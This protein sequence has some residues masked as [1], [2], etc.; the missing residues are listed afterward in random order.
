MPHGP[1]VDLSIVVPMY[2]E[3]EVID[4]FFAR[5]HEVL[6]PLDLSWEIVAVNDGSSDQTLVMLR[7]R[8][9]SEPGLVVVDLSRNFGKERALTAGLD[10][11][12]GRAVVPIDADLQDPP[13]LIPRFI[14][15]WREGYHVVYGVRED[16]R[17]DSLLKRLTAGWFYRVFNGVTEVPIPNHT[18]DF[19]LMDRRV[20]DAL[21][22]LPERNRFMKGLFA[23]VG[24]R[25]V[26][27]PF[28]RPQ[29]AAGITKFSGWRLW[30]FAI[31]GITGFSTVPLRIWSYVGVLVSLVAF[32]YATF[33]VLRTLVLGVDVPGYASLLTIMLFLGG[34]QLIS[35]GVI[36][37]YLGRIYQEVK[38][39]PTYLVHEV[40]RGTEPAAPPAVDHERPPTE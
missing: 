9:A 15:K 28:E 22:L 40:V 20:L 19:R 38:G 8:V 37:E 39:R 13:E 5:M 3:A 31:D 11:A 26:G 10:H 6:D 18:G 16:R 24:F 36:G 33:I 14:E 12:S 23:W 17:D 29:R 21:A 2:N 25:S 4:L 35:L 34:V 1:T 30:N 32:S 7:E 27:V